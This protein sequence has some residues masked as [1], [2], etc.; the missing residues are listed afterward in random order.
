MPTANA[1]ID[2]ISYANNT[3]DSKSS[4]KSYAD[5]S[6]DFENVFNEVNKAYS[7]GKETSKNIAVKKDNEKDQTVSDI[8]DKPTE[9]TNEKPEKITEESEDKDSQKDSTKG[10]E[11]KSSVDNTKE[12]TDEIKT[13]QVTDTKPDSTEEP[14]QKQVQTPPQEPQIVCNITN[15]NVSD[16]L[17]EVLPATT[18][19]E[20]VDLTNKQNSNNVL[21]VQSEPAQ[22]EPVQGK[23]IG[24]PQIG[25][26][27]IGQTQA[28]QE[29][30][31]VDL[32][33]LTNLDELTSNKPNNAN[34]QAQTQQTLSNLKVNTQESSPQI[35]QPQITVEQTQPQEKVEVPVIEVNTNVLASDTNVNTSSTT[36][37]NSEKDIQ[38][39]LNKTTLTQETLNKT[40]AK[41][42]NIE[43]S[44]SSNSNNLLNNQNA[45]EQVVKLSLEKDNSTQNSIQT[46]DLTN[47]P[48][49]DITDTINQANF[50]K[51]LDSVQTQAPKA[52][53][54]TDILSQ[55]NNQL[56][57]QKPLEEETKINIVLKP[58]NLGKINLELV[59]S[60][61]GLIAKM[62]TDNAQVKELLNKNLDSLKETLSNQGI[63]VNSVTVKIEETQK[64][65]NNMFS[66]DNKQSQAGNQ[67]FSNNAQKQNQSEFSF[68]EKNDSA[69][70]QM[71]TDLNIETDSEV[72]DL[73]S[74][75]AYS[76]RVDYKV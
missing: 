39:A 29:D 27:Q 72:E 1:I 4:T 26:L 68:D 56:N 66:F 32:T 16:T 42:V 58:E 38:D 12:K 30:F 15:V 35:S 62:T 43:N 52:L 71:E 48:D 65:S 49:A 8:T 59:N 45:Q 2:L 57:T 74:A 53:N 22:S 28:V 13:E 63:N 20:V 11:E 34:I 18:N 9:N 50:T 67:E 21:P 6:N 19:T 7:A 23:Q 31:S 17:A 54:K 37:T 41:V 24:Q 36:N 40:N 25:Q 44:D 70:V 3:T 33:N 76:G 73:V 75:G 14:T 64:Q 60:K 55:I 46:L 61:E 10:T 5:N 47:I 69:I 51:T